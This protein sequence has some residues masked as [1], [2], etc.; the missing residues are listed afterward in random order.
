MLA[1]AVR[2]ATG[3]PLRGAG[4]PGRGPLAPAARRLGG[5]PVRR[6]PTCAAC[7][8]PASSSRCRWAASRCTPSTSPPCP[9]RR[10]R[11]RSA[12]GV[13]IVPGGLAGLEPGRRWVVR[14][15]APIVTRRRADHRRPGRAGRGRRATGCSTCSRARGPHQAPP[16]GADGVRRAD[17][18]SAPGWPAAR[19]AAHGVRPGCRRHPAALRG[20][21]APRRRAAAAWCRDS[22]PTA[23]DGC[24]SDGPWPPATAASCSTT[25]APVAPTTRPVPTTSRSWRP[26]RWPCSTRPASS[27]PTCMGASMGGAIAQIIGVRHPERT[28]SL[29]LA[30]TACRHHEWR[31]EL[32]AEWAAVAAREGMGALAQQAVRWLIGPRSLRR[33]WPAVGLIGPLAMTGSPDPFVAQ[34]QA[35]LAM[36]DG[37][38]R[39]LGA[40]EVPTLVMVGSQD[41]LTPH[42]RQRGAGRADPRC[43]AGRD[44]RCGAR[45]HARAGRR[46]Q[47]HRPRVPQP[48]RRCAGSPA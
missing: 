2:R 26:T 11:W 1:T 48:G 13:P 30:C 39:E 29:M 31:R 10:S 38:R 19:F 35:I 14:F 27:A 7:C 47:P 44:P 4:A 42:G 25:A 24:A 8:G 40:I 46:L 17:A 32:L 9:S 18:S 43:R 37:L 34:V 33:L 21:R 45:L 15:G 16:T 22:A 20:L 5:V 28:R 3:R 36:D 12:L 41:I 23:G 6:R